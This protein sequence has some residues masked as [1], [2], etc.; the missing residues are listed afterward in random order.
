M[1]RGSLLP[2]TVHYTAAKREGR[3]RLVQ[4]SLGLILDSPREINNVPSLSINSTLPPSTAILYYSRR[5]FSP[6]FSPE[7]STQTNMAS[8]NR[9]AR[10]QS[11]SHFLSPSLT[12]SLSH[13]LLLSSLN[14]VEG[15]P[16]LQRFSNVKNKK[17]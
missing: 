5:E 12:L 9:L 14:R 15:S 1:K 11:L 13:S 17:E 10:S 4:E 6:E 2:T 7:F 8:H 16:V 3:E